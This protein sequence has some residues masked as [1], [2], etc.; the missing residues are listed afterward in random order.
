MSARFLARASSVAVAVAVAVSACI[1]TEHPEPFVFPPSFDDADASLP[2]DAD[3]PPRPDAGLPPD[4]VRIASLNVHLFFDTVCQ[5]GRCAPGDFEQQPTEAAFEARADQIAQGLRALNPSIVLLQEIETRA[6]LDALKSRLG[7]I[8]P[9]SVMSSVGGPGSVN[10][11]VLAQG[12]LLEFHLHTDRLTRPDGTATSF[13]R[14]LVEVHVSLDGARVIVFDAHFRSKSNDDPGR[15]LAEAQASGQ[16]I[17]AAAAK[18]PDALV[19]FGGDLNDEPG[20]PP[21]DALEANP[22]LWRVEQVLPLA[23]Q[24]TYPS[25]GS[26]LDHLFQQ[27]AAAGAFLPG[28]VRVTCDSPRGYAGSDHCAISADFALPTVQAR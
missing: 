9:S 27:T 15:R 16:I 10:T 19:V 6:S 28:Q 17:S 21:M 20:S 3:V 2:P 18:F 4:A 13:T 8:L 26:R 22:Q 24:V 12:A 25:W 23:Q 14:A 1:S 7:D 5:S 11:A